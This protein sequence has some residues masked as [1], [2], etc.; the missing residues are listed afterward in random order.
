M[1][2][3]VPEWIGRADLLILLQLSSYCTNF[4]WV[5]GKGKDNRK[6]VEPKLNWHF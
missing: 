5:I 2:W 4:N 3:Q 1:L 6:A